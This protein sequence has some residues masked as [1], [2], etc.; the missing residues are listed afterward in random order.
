MIDNATPGEDTALTTDPYGDTV[1]DESKIE[2]VIETVN[3]DQWES[4]CGDHLIIEAN[5]TTY[6]QFFRPF[7]KGHPVFSDTVTLSL[8][9]HSETIHEIR[10]DSIPDSAVTT[11]DKRLR[12]L[13]RK[14]AQ[15]EFSEEETARMEILTARL[16]KMVPRVDVSDFEKLEQMAQSLEAAE[17]R[18]EALRRKL[19]L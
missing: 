10:D 8:S 15:K 19:N 9:G 7:Y 18:T 12:L 17:K 11:R 3:D 16:R 4:G 13:A 1:V 5:G 14:Y 6:L 2:T